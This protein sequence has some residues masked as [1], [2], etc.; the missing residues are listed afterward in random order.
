MVGLIADAAHT[1]KVGIDAPE[2]S[3]YLLGAGQPVLEGSEYLA[4][5]H[6]QTGER[7]PAIDLA[8]ERALCRVLAD[9]VEAGLVRTA[10]DVADGGIAVA[11]AEM[12]LASAGLGARV[13]IEIEDRS[14]TA[15]FGE[16]GCRAIVAID[17]ARASELESLVAKGRVRYRRL[18]TTGGERL[19]IEDASGGRMLVDAS[20]EALRE[21]WEAALPHI[22]SG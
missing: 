22:A 3:L 4:L 8:G 18:G 17:P 10:H 14:D 6:G 12:C 19:T 7:P 1:A 2:L 13:A 5:R 20:L 16:S 15:L 9:L 21:R 11:L